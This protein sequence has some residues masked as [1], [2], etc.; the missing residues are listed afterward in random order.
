M[1]SKLHKIPKIGHFY[2]VFGPAT[3]TDRNLIVSGTSLKW[4]QH[5][6]ALCTNMHQMVLIHRSSSAVSC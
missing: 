2:A 1:K 6:A 3:V 4:S 5:D